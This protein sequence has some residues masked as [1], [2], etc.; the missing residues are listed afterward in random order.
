VLVSYEAVGDL[1][2]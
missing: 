2:A 1:A